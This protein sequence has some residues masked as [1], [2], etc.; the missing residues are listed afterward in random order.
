M[1]KQ[2]HCLLLQRE[3]IWRALC[4]CVPGSNTSGFETASSITKRV[5]YLTF[6]ITVFMA[7]TLYQSVLLKALMVWFLAKRACSAM[8]LKVRE[9]AIST[10][11][12]ADLVDDFRTG[13]RRAIFN[14]RSSGSETMFRK[15][16]KK[17]K[18]LC[19]RVFRAPESMKRSPSTRQSIGRAEAGTLYLTTF[20]P[21][22]I[23][24]SST[25]TILCFT[26]SKSGRARS[27]TARR[28]SGIRFPS[29][30][31]TQWR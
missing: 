25:Q 19:D 30:L 27:N 1:L 29:S 7:A 21:R 3:P 13:R 24:C 10:R 4:A 23:W 2:K 9:P 31:L 22:A 6:G 12:L 14:G 5:L 8:L 18:E 16:S 28:T 20:T 26:C 11:T 17:R 15:V